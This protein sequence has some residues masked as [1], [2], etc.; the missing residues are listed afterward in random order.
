MKSPKFWQRK[1]LISY[2]LLPISLLYQI[3]YFVKSIYQII[4]YRNS[5]QKV[6]TI[7]IANL[8]LGG[9]GKTPISLAIGKL[10]KQKNIK[11]SYLSK[12]YGGKIK[13]LTKVS[14]K[15]NAIDVGDEPLL[16][17]EISNSFI[18]KKITSKILQNQELSKNDY[19]IIDDGF[20]NFAWRKNYSILVIDG[21]YAFGNEM[22]FPSGPLRE[23]IKLGIRR[24]DLIILI[25]KDRHNIQKR[26]CQN[27]KFINVNLK[28]I[29]G[30]DFKNKNIC[31]FAGI[32][33]PEKLFNSLEESGANIKHK[34]KFSDHYQYSKNDL[35]KLIKF[36]KER[37]L[38]LVTTKKD[39]VR[40][41]KIY[42]KKIKFLD[43]EMI[44]SE[45][46]LP[47]ININ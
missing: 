3:G 40:L 46:I 13:N 23:S 43:I 14:S 10:L 36:A 47:T 16:L 21:N 30:N 7:C 19:I 20:Q 41:D 37:N 45:D 11:F 32:T 28:I 4:F 38:E 44:L 8:T 33:R 18:C 9:S 2:L 29:N 15:H 22:I 24:V 35:K 5:K 25:G 39:W 1:S 34:I 42:Q 31:A 17:K 27:K 26:F 12:G 6:K